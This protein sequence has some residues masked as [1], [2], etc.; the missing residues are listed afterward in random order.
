MIDWLRK[1]TTGQHV[2]TGNYRFHVRCEPE[3]IDTASTINITTFADKTETSVIPS[4]FRWFR[5]RNG[6]T[7]EIIKY[8]GSSYICEPSDVGAIIKV[9]ILS[10]DLQ[11]YGKANI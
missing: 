2:A 5:V 9:E 8:K 6:L 3:I 7:E 1:A 4:T 11:H 10:N